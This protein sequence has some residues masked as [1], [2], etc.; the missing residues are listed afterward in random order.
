MEWIGIDLHMHTQEG[1]TRD[2]KNDVVNF[3]YV[4]FVNA[5]LKRL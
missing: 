5:V 2:G 1:V 4:D 3:T